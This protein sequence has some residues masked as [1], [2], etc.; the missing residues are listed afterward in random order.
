M[1][2]PHSI[3]LL[4]ALLAGGSAFAQ[5]SAPAERPPMREHA[6]DRLKAAD[7]N[8]DGLISKAEAEKSMP[9]LAAH[10]DQIDT[11]KDGQLSPEEL[12]AMADKMPRHD[13]HG[14]REGAHAPFGGADAN[15]DHVV[16]RDELIQ[17]HQKMLEDF[18]AADTNKDGKL[19]GDEMKAFHDK[20]RA[21]RP[22]RG[23]TP[24]P[25]SPSK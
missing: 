7:T 5:Q 13:R 24:P 15:H 25:S 21:Q 10:F 16:T 2:T 4:I 14:G 11:N 23:E 18:D 12:K 3:V 20:M 8:K 17:H 9:H 19:T 22:P 6:M 1:K